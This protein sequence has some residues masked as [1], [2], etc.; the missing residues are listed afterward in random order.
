MSY[1]DTNI[2]FAGSGEVT[3]YYV[4]ACNGDGCSAVVGAPTL[5]PTP[6]PTPTPTPTPA[7][8]TPTATAAVAGW[9]DLVVDA[10]TVS[11]S[12]LTVR[13]IFSLN[14]VIRNQGSGPASYV[15][16]R[17]V[18]STDASTT[19]RSDDTRENSY[20]ARSSWNDWEDAT[21]ELGPSGSWPAPTEARA[22][23]MSGIY[24][25]YACVDAV[26]GESDTTN[27]CSDMV[28]V[29]VAAPTPPP[30]ILFPPADVRAVSVGPGRV[31][32]SWTAVRVADYYLVYHNY[33]NN[34][35]GSSLLGKLWGS[36][37]ES[38]SYMH[39][40]PR[41]DS[42]YYF[43]RACSERIVAL[44]GP[45]GCRLAR[46][47]W[48]GRS[49]TQRP[50][51]VPTPGFLRPT[52]TPV[53]GIQPYLNAPETRTEAW[54][55]WF[56]LQDAHNNSYSDKWGPHV[57]CGGPSRPCPGQD[58]IRWWLSLPYE[59]QACAAHGICP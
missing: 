3:H 17:F 58:H 6:V 5:T 1:V 28:M 38:M 14:A 24:Y 45:S 47:V 29:A 52:P 57:S 55:R 13:E 32:I 26:A 27:N 20:I 40:T 22:P 25:Y 41:H 59:A 35:L 8:P 19:T 36:E 18:R 16:M 42:N 56:N 7:T 48:A 30:G 21:Y 31:E 23:S 49:T 46:P 39:A 4:R 43:I 54:R 50:N 2:A 11:D 34:I 44:E 12:S 33:F 15:T 10:L 37:G 51:I 9:P 53:P